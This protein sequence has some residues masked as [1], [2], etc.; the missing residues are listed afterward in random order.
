MLNIIFYVFVAVAVVQ[1]VYYLGIFGKFSFAKPQAITPKRLSVSVVVCA[2]NDAEKVKELIPVLATQNYP[3]FELVLID[4]AS[5]DETLDVFEEFEKQYANI[6]LVKVENNEAFWG[7]KKYALTLG[8]KAARKDYL[9]F[10]DAHCY[11]TSPDWILSM[12]SQF[13]LNKTIILGYSAYEKTKS[14][15]NKIIR[16]NAI[17]TATQQFAWAK[18]GKPFTGDGRNLAYKKDEFF[19]RNGYINHMSIPTGADALFVN[20]AATK[21]N[22]AV[23]YAPESFT[24]SKAQKTFAE[25]IKEKRRAAFTA[26]FFKPLD[27]FVVK[28]FT[29]FQVAFFVLA[30]VLLALQYNWMF[31]V[32][33]I[34]I[35]YIAAWITVAQ[36]AA[37]LNEKDAAYWFPVMEIIL[38]FTQLYVY[39]ANLTSKP[40]HWK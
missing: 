4:N 25:F 16:F 18:L 20:D 15:L 26:S 29:F 17:I 30:I 14:F 37:R 31:I 1:L 28:L 7:N 9:L 23:C 21:K 19:K 2:K 27:R 24:Y 5:S 22:T 6:R 11:P 33:V 3:D 32:P 39:I 13:T 10:T 35:R 38:I 8:I 12:T 40:V 34:A 36:S